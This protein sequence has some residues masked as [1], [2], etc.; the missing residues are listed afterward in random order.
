ME[1]TVFLFQNVLTDLQ[2]RPP[3]QDVDERLAVDDQRPVLRT[4][5]DTSGHFAELLG[6]RDH[7][8]RLLVLLLD[9]VQVVPD[10]RLGRVA[11]PRVQLYDLHF[12]EKS[13]ND[14]T[15]SLEM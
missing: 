14:N 4:S 11:A 10:R 6:G 12:L 9:V 15:K 2:I 8:A 7:G 1:R 13:S 3:V 5:P